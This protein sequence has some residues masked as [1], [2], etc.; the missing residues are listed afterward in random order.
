MCNYGSTHDPSVSHTGTRGNPVWYYIVHGY[1]T[2]AAVSVYCHH[3]RCDT[4]LKPHES[5]MQQWTPV[6]L[7]MHDCQR[8]PTLPVHLA[9]REWFRWQIHIEQVP[10]CP[11]HKLQ[12]Y[13]RGW[14]TI[15]LEA[16]H[17]LPVEVNTQAIPYTLDTGDSLLPNWVCCTYTHVSSRWPYEDE[18]TLSAVKYTSTFVQQ[19]ITCNPWPGKL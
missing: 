15:T 10:P 12:W 1:H 19:C 11:T 6:Y 9:E 2:R 13:T 8:K 4:Y 18:Q 5:S 7:H 17:G 16:L 3:F 14:D